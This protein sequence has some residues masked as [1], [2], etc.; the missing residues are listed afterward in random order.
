MSIWQ[1]ILIYIVLMV[2]CVLG[3]LIRSIFLDM[4]KK[5]LIIALII[6]FFVFLGLVIK[7]ITLKKVQLY[8]RLRTSD[9]LL[10]NFFSGVCCDVFTYKGVGGLLV[11]FCGGFILADLLGWLFLFGSC[12]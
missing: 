4:N 3:I 2:I 7:N 5:D 1:S 8:H 10:H 9:F 6:A 11:V 12:C